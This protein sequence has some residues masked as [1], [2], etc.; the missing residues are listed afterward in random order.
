MPS[1]SVAIEVDGL[2]KVYRR[3]VSG[4]TRLTEW[5]APK[6]DTDEFWALKDVSF[7]VGRGMVLGIIGRNGAGKSTLL[8]ILARVTPPTSGT[9]R[10]SGRVASLLEVGT[11][12]HQE[13]TGRENVF[14]SAAILGMGRKEIQRRFDEIV[15]FSGIGAF[16]DTPVKRYSSGM[17]VRLGFAVAAHLDA[18]VLLVD[19]VLAVGD[20]EFRR[21]CLGRISDLT[22][23]GRTV[24]LV[25]HEM[26]TMSQLSDRVLYLE[27]GEVEYLGQPEEAVAEYLNRFS[28]RENVAVLDPDPSLE[29]DFVSASMRGA[30]GSPGAV[31]CDE[32]LTIEFTMGLQKRVPDLYVAFYLRKRD[33]TIALFSDSRDCQP[34]LGRGLVPGE[35]TF[36]VDIP[37]RT[38]APGSYTLTLG[39]SSHTD[40]PLT[41]RPDVCGITVHDFTAIRGDSR[42][43][44]IG[45]LLEWKNVD[46][47]AS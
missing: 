12:F 17:Y 43:G 36:R 26:S 2:S 20:A 22:G 11:G 24:V 3:G 21:R 35:H 45:L 14:L 34:D 30:N 38:L 40:G 7:E 5:R 10:I 31:S 44:S 4:S 8:R 32:A 9:A 33:G 47:H 6:A 42:P 41:N 13:L 23:S 39:A 18:D 19:E 25:S 28:P 16:I 46:S 1:D 27:A 29:A 37:A 15:D